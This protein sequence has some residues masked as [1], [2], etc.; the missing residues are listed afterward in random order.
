MLQS[1]YHLSPYISVFK[2]R[3]MLHVSNLEEGYTH[4][5]SV[6]TKVYFFETKQIDW[7]NAN[8]FLFY[9]TFVYCNRII[10]I[11]GIGQLVIIGFTKTTAAK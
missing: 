8:L 3:N 1:L 9:L 10:L 11:E 4:K 2:E 6:Y 7:S 5:S